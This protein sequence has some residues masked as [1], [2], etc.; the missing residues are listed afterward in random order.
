MEKSVAELLGELSFIGRPVE[1]LYLNETRVSEHF[2]G[3]LGA[4]ESFTRTATR[5]GSIEAPV[6]KVSGG[7][8]SDRSIT[9]SLKEP[10]TQAL[11]LRAALDDRNLLTGISH[12]KVGSYV[13]FSG[14]ALI[15]H[16]LYPFSYMHREV[17][18]AY[19][20]LYE[21]LEEERAKK[22]D[23]WRM[24]GTSD[25]NIWILTVME[26]TSLCAAFLDQHWIT[27]DAIHWLSNKLG[28]RRMAILDGQTAYPDFPSCEIFALLREFHE[29]GVP[30]LATL[31]LAL[32]L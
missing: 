32:K 25:Q 21:A 13:T 30:M 5:N 28:A 26:G 2:I 20:G 29:T 14:I 23:L 4:I 9:W 17:L 24:L 15:S 6:V 8:S 7:A 27:H 18:H 22:E 31:H 11:V 10:V 3:Q 16:P 1:T 12:A 19:P